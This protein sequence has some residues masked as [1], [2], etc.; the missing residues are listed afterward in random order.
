MKYAAAMVLLF[1]GIQW[2]EAFGWIGVAGWVLFAAAVVWILFL[3]T[4]VKKLKSELAFEREEREKLSKEVADLREMVKGLKGRIM[5]EV[6]EK[7]LTSR[8]AIKLREDMAVMKKANATNLA[9]INKLV[10]KYG[11]V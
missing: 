1:T 10:E 11:D 7:Y 8:E 6:E 3:H 2:A 9:T 4:V 5:N